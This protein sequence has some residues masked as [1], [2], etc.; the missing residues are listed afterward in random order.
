MK[1]RNLRPGQDG[2]T[3]PNH[4][5]RL[6]DGDSWIEPLTVRRKANGKYCPKDGHEP[7]SLLLAVQ[8]RR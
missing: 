3:P 6:W 4:S 5:W 2:P 8:K 1:T 7:P